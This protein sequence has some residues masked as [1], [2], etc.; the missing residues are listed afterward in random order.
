MT[1]FHYDP[2]EMPVSP[3]DLKPSARFAYPIRAGLLTRPD[4]QVKFVEEYSETTPN[5]PPDQPHPFF[6][7]R[8]SRPLHPRLL[9]SPRSSLAKGWK[10]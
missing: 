9:D 6:G 4:G 2:A 3:F 5:Y 8:L 10:P 1:L 7:F